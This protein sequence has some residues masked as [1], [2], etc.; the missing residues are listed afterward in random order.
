MENLVNIIYALILT[1]WS[2]MC[3]TRYVM[4]YFIYVSSY[5]G[6]F[7]HDVLVGG[8]EYGQFFF[9]LLAILPVLY[10]WKE[11]D[12]WIRRMMVF[13][14]LFYLYGLAKPVIDGHQGWILSVKSSK[15]MTSYFF[16]FYVLAF[17]RQLDFDRIFRFVTML[18]FYYSI[19]YLVN[20][21]GIGIK[22]PMYVKGQ[23]IQCF[24]DSFLL[25]ALCYRLTREEPFA[26]K[27]LWVVGGLLGGIYVSGYFSLFAVAVCLVLGFYLYQSVHHPLV[28]ILL[29][30]SVCLFFTLD[31]IRERSVWRFWDDHQEALDSRIRYNEFRWMLISR[32]LWGGYG[33]LSRETR[34]VSMNSMAENS[35][36]MAD[37]SFIDAGYVDL[38]GRFG[39]IGT[40]LFLVVPL[41]FICTASWSRK[42]LPF[43]LLLVSFYAVNMTWAV[44]SFP[45]GIVVLALV[46]AFLYQNKKLEKWQES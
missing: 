40:F 23:F 24:Y 28:W 31:S 45:Q 26:G 16:L 14:F 44:F 6:W 1:G 10:S 27:N 21:V 46:Y 5:L 18:A 38:M 42:T 25:L 30:L 12:V 37:L 15:S 35:S 19:L 17:Y 34:L 22:P 11:L 39:L 36:Y 9:N 8:V 29:I 2:F 4:G 7:S 43:V 3:P 33:F 32:E 13:L 20:A 41:C